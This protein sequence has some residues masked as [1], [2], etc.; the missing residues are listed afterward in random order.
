MY[1]RFVVASSGKPPYKNVMTH[2]FVLDASGRK[3]SKSEGNVVAPSSIVKKYA[4]SQW[5]FV[6]VVFL[7]FILRAAV[8]FS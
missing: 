8:G 6:V 5:Y 4:V 7:F 3:M 1:L 2:G